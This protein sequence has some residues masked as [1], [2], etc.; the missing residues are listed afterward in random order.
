MNNPDKE[1]KKIKEGF[2][3]Q[4]MIVLPPNIKRGLAN[5]ALVKHLYATAI[6]LLSSCG[7]S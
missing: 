2:V 3:G 5:N 7:F 6:G 4:K 1:D